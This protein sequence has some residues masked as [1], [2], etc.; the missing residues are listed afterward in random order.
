MLNRQYLLEKLN[1]RGSTSA[2]QSSL[3]QEREYDNKG[4]KVIKQYF[5]FVAKKII[6]IVLV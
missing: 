4:H 5:D 1:Q 3:A 2:L 6:R